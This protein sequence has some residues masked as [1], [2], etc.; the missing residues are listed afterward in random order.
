VAR[1][2]E[3]RQRVELKDSNLE[4]LRARCRLPDL[5]HPRLVADGDQA[6]RIP[7]ADVIDAYQTCHFD[8]HA[9]LLLALAPRRLGGAFVV[10]DESAGQAPHPIRRLYTAAA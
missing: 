5:D 4:H 3:R 10:V 1:E 9:D 7:P 6:G 2:N 8:G